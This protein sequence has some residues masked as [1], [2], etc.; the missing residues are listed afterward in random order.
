MDGITKISYLSLLLFYIRLSN[1]QMVQ[2]IANKII[3]PYMAN[4]DMA[5]FFAKKC[6][7]LKAY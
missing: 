6:F 3:M 4:F 1:I 7:T 5:N 2:L